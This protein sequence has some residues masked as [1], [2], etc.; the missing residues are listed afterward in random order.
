VIDAA[1]PA[2]DLFDDPFAHPDKPLAQE[3][4]ADGRIAV[5]VR[6]AKP[7]ALTDRPT[8]QIQLWSRSE[9]GARDQMLVSSLPHAD[10]RQLRHRNRGRPDHP[11]SRDLRVPL[12]ASP[13]TS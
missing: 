4:L 9:D 3:R 12:I 8:R 1:Q 7:I 11:R 5:P 6:S 13:L 2:Q 10:P